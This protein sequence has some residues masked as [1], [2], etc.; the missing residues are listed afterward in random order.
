MEQVTAPRIYPRYQGPPIEQL[1]A[2]LRPRLAGA[3]SAAEDNEISISINCM[4]LSDPTGWQVW[5][6][7]GF[8]NYA[9]VYAFMRANMSLNAA[10][11]FYRGEVAPLALELT[12]Q[13]TRE[14]GIEI[15]RALGL[16]IVARCNGDGLPLGAVNGIPLRKV[17]RPRNACHEKIH[18]GVLETRL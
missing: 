11:F 5:S 4:Q 16:E 2:P 17:R 3:I 12:G 10:Y 6:G 1:P 13:I 8:A 9:E 15:E 7:L 14:Q 18:M